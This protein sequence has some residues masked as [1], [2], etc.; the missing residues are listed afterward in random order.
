MLSCSAH[1]GGHGVWKPNNQGS[2]VG[3]W[4]QYAP[5]TFFSDYDGAIAQARL[6]HRP[7]PTAST[8]DWY[9]AE[10]QAYAAG[11]ARL[12]TDYTSTGHWT[13]PYCA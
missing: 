13:D 6:L 3:G 11:Y 5:G 8:R 7:R 10:G 9:S 2:G 1:E 4:M 12:Y